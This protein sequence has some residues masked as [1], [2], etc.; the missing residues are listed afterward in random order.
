MICSLFVNTAPDIYHFDHPN[1]KVVMLYWRTFLVIFI[2]SNFSSKAFLFSSLEP[3][4]DR[5]GMAE[6]T[7]Q[8]V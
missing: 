3:V 1:C 2:C 7:T 4:L 6:C 5:W 8:P